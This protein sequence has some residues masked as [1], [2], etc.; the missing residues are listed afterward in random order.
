MLLVRITAQ[1]GSGAVGPAAALIALIVLVVGVYVGWQLRHAYG[2][3]SD[4]KVHKNRIPNFR[5]ARNRSWLTSLL[6]VLAVMFM[7]RIL[8]K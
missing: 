7:L 6:L 8:I 4:L 3:N 5:K 1:G 2:A